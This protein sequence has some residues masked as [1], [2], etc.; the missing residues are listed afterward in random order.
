MPPFIRLT[1]FVIVLASAMFPPGSLPAVEA[2]MPKPVDRPDG[3]TNLAYI[4][5]GAKPATSSAECMKETNVANLNDGIYGPLGSPGSP[6]RVPDRVGQDVEN[7]PLQVLARRPSGPSGAA[8][9][10][11]SLH[12]WQAMAGGF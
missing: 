8:H 11:R 7:W 3:P 9:E 5:N 1:F 10:D 4:G 2:P 6:C 12:G